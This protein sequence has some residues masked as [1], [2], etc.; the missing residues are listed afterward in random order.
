MASRHL[1]RETESEYQVGSISA[2][3][4]AKNACSRKRIYHMPNNLEDT[5]TYLEVPMK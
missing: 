1:G 4:Y 5:K 3:T 2:V